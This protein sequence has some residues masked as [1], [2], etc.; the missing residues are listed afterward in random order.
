MSSLVDL[1]ER[2][3]KLLTRC[4]EVDRAASELREKGLPLDVLTR[5]GFEAHTELRAVEHQIAKLKEPK[6]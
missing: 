3:Q 4:A 1:L 5:A 6:R 2:R